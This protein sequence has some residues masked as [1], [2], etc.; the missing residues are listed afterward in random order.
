[1]S[2]LEWYNSIKKGDFIKCKIHIDETKG[3]GLYR[4]GLPLVEVVL[5]VTGKIKTKV[6]E[7]YSYMLWVDGKYQFDENG[8][9]IMEIINYRD[10]PVN[11]NEY[12]KTIK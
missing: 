5:P 2:D 3:C 9:F 1:M 10:Y 12:I 7:E 6:L 11:R 4:G 8:N